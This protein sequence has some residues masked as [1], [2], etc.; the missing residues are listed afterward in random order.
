MDKL[1]LPNMSLTT[2]LVG[3]LITQII[4]AGIIYWFISTA[5]SRKIHQMMG[6]A[7]REFFFKGFDEAARESIVA[8]MKETHDQAV[9]TA[10]LAITTAKDLAKKTAREADVVAERLHQIDRQLQDLRET[11]SKIDGMSADMHDTNRSIA[12]LHVRLTGYFERANG[13]KP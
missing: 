3:Y 2:V 10:E 6:A 11:F 12:D 1:V 7:G 5:A 4:M 9:Q 8:I 13:N